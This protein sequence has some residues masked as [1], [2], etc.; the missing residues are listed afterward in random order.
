[1]N[2]LFECKVKYEKIDD[3][4][5]EKKVTETYLVDAVSHGE[6][7]ARIYKEMESIIRGEFL[8]KGVRPANYTE[9][10]DKMEGDRF[11]KSKISFASVDDKSGKEKVVSNQ[12]LV[13]ANTVKE[14]YDN[15]MEGIGGMTV[16]FN[17]NSV[18]ESPI[19]EFFKYDLEEA[20]AEIQKEDVKSNAFKD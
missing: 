1:M 2:N 6:A 8:V 15:I 18:G 7:E 16:D 12:I 17:I 13:M 10:F 3:H 20:A 9:V 19:L 4:G 5:R 14:A 11:Y